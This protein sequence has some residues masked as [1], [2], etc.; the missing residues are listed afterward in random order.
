MFWVQQFVKQNADLL[1]KNEELKK[2]SPGLQLLCDDEFA[3]AKLF[4]KRILNALTD[5]PD[6]VRFIYDEHQVF[7]RDGQPLSEN[8]D[9]K[10]PFELKKYFSM[11]R[12]WTGKHSKGVGSFNSY[13]LLFPLYTL[14]FAC[15][16][17]FVSPHAENQGPCLHRIHALQVPR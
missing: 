3:K 1:E 4:Q 15:S 7:F 6:P 9:P 8:P 16:S 10:M 2:W 11:F 5:H 17:Y 14:T 12:T 13:N